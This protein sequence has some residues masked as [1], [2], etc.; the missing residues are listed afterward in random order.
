[1]KANVALLGFFLSNEALALSLYS[2][3]ESAEQ[4]STYNCKQILLKPTVNKM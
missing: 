4:P 3:S 2:L 1:M